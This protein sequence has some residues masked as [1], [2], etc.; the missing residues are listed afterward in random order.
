MAAFALMSLPMLVTTAA[1]TIG[2]VSSIRKGYEQ[3]SMLKTQAGMADR[4]ADLA[5]QEAAYRE[6]E[7]LEL[8]RRGEIT[9]A[10][11]ARKGEIEQKL[12]EDKSR[13]ILGEMRARMARGG[14]DINTGSPLDLIGS[15]AESQGY[16]RELMAWDT[17]MNIWKTRREGAIFLD[18]A[19]VLNTQASIYR[20]GAKSAVI[21]GYLGAAGS[22]LSM[23][24][25][26]KG[27]GG[28]GGG[29]GSAT[30]ISD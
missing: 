7:A 8:E 6:T 13:L 17:S 23:F 3:E 28:D 30:K 14:M 18:R 22:A 5:R 9:E 11:L 21:G 16:E 2:A 29:T 20:Q 1:A 12:Q 19:K 4:D 26:S 15:T 25:L 27:F 24:A 10:Q